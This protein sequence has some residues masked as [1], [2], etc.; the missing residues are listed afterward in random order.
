MWS[1]H[2]LLPEGDETPTRVLPCGPWILSHTGIGSLL[3]QDLGLGLDL[4]PRL[5]LGP[6]LALDPGL[7]LDPG[8]AH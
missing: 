3:L 5:A 6:G 8:L 1:E 7:V 4:G 2:W